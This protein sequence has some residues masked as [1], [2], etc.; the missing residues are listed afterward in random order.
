LV[1]LGVPT[2]YGYYG[3]T[4]SCA[5]AIAKKKNELAEV[6]QMPE[7]LVG[8]L[9]Q[10]GAEPVSL[11]TPIG[12]EGDT[13]L[14]D[15]VSDLSAPTPF[16]VVSTSLLPGEIDKLLAPLDEREREIIRL[17]YGLDR[18]EPRTLEEVGAALELTRERIRQIERTALSKLR[19]PSADNGAH[20]LLAS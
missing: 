18:G 1:L 12:S 4:S 10:Y 6:M 19:H 13:E 8:E 20:D 15:I 3:P 7:E 17:R 9:L 16:D 2:S 5:F 14:A 11:E